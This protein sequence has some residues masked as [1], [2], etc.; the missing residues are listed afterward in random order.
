M[1]NSNFD[2]IPGVMPA[3][4]NAEDLDFDPTMF[5]DPLS[6]DDAALILKSIKAIKASD[7]ILD[8]DKFDDVIDVLSDLE[9]DDERHMLKEHARLEQVLRCDADTNYVPNP[10]PPSKLVHDNWYSGKNVKRKAP[11]EMV[12]KGAFTMPEHMWKKSKAYQPVSPPPS[13]KNFMLREAAPPI[14][15]PM[16]GP[17]GLITFRPAI[18]RRTGQEFT[19]TIRGEALFVGSDG[20]YYGMKPGAMRVIKTN[21]KKKYNKA[22]INFGSIKTKNGKM[23]SN[24]I[25][26]HNIM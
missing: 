9:E 7:I 11:E 8:C 2:L 12:G 22:F 19:P 23:G 17:G 5:E 20:G 25:F 10:T 26:V 24:Q 14:N 15:L 16:P 1:S 13:P 3:N 6:D 4:I 21:N 18:D